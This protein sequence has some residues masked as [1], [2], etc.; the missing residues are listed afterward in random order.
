MRLAGVVSVGILASWYVAVYRAA[1]VDTLLEYMRLSR[2]ETIFDYL[3]YRLSFMT[4]LLTFLPGLLIAAPALF[5]WARRREP[6]DIS[7]RQTARCSWRSVL[8]ATIPTIALVVWPGAATR[9]AT[10]AL[11]AVAALAG[12]CL[13]RLLRAASI[14]RGSAL[15]ILAGLI[16][17]QFVWGWIVAPLLPDT[18]GKTRIDAHIVEAATRAKPYTIYAPLRLDDAVLAYLDRP[19][20]YLEGEQLMALPAPAYLLA[21]PQTADMIGKAARTSRS[22]C[23]RRSDTNRSASTK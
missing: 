22:S 19:V 10:P 4:I 11:L 17:Y 14:L 12:L 2:K 20:R 21:E 5:D 18:F 8:Y 16:A 6:A 7:R 1:D 13:D 3:A 23:T 9:Y 15:S